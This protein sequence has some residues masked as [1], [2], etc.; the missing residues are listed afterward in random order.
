MENSTQK[1]AK[2]SKIDKNMTKTKKRQ[3]IFEKN[4]PKRTKITIK[5]TKKCKPSKNKS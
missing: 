1:W 4:T 5:R 3:K 2:I